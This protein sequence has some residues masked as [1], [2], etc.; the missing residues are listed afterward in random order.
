MRVLTTVTTKLTP[1]FLNV[2]DIE[3]LPYITSRT[4]DLMDR[5]DRYPAVEQV[6][7]LLHDSYAGLRRSAPT[8]HTYIFCSISCMKPFYLCFGRLRPALM[9][10]MGHC[11]TGKCCF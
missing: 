10:E 6:M 2:I 7:S 8:H 11:G 3:H 9:T 4:S 5:H 1:L